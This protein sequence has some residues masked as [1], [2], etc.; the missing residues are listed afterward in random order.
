MLD[1]LV[2][3]KSSWSLHDTSKYRLAISQQTI[4]QSL[5]CQTS[6]DFQILLDMFPMD[7]LYSRRH[8]SFQ[9]VGVPV[10]P[11][12]SFV[13]KP[14]LEVEVGDD[15]YLHPDFIRSLTAIRQ[16]K[17]AREWLFPN[18]YLFRDNSLVEYTCPEGRRPVVVARRFTDDETAVPRRVV[19]TSTRSWIHVR[20][21]ENSTAIPKMI[22]GLETTLSWPG[23][24]Q[25]LVA[26]VSSMKIPTATAV[27]YT[28]DVYG[29]IIDP[30]MCRRGRTRRK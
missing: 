7:P 17:D 1:V 25:G 12:H 2:R 22:G 4:I 19:H 21:L 3:I 26:R 6:K 14:R 10:Q 8:R 13:H 9:S 20:H 11:Q 30:E 5:T 27:G 29:R 28:I 24:H 16:P 15:D 23:W 18:G